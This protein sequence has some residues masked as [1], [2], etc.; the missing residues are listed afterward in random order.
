M[1]ACGS[2]ATFKSQI[3]TLKTER[4]IAEMSF[5]IF[6]RYHLNYVWNRVL[7]ISP[8]GRRIGLWHLYRRSP[9][10]VSIVS[11]KFHIDRERQFLYEF[12]LEKLVFLSFSGYLDTTPFFSACPIFC[13]GQCIQFSGPNSQ[14]RWHYVE[15]QETLSVFW[16]AQLTYSAKQDNVSTI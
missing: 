4:G 8:N 5:F 15:V 6:C 7:V 14:K 16:L 11:T 10:V 9:F 1:C 3:E 13:Q 2:N 12:S